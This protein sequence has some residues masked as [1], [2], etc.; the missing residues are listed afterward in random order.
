MAVM[1]KT[2]KTDLDAM[3][4]I[5]LL[6]EDAGIPAL[7]TGEIRIIQRRLDSAKEDCVINTLLWDADQ[8]QGGVFNINFHVPNLSGQVGENPTAVDKTQPDVERMVELGKIAVAALDD[9]HGYDFSLK[10]RN[11][12]TVE[13]NG[14]TEWLYNIQVDY[15]HLRTD[16]VN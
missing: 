2:I 11:P 12:G 4:D 13:G 10:L 15:I 7:I 6:L 5:R 14:S 1:D 16:K 9:H 8:F 3:N